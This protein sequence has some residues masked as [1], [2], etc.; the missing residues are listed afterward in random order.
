MSDP[1]DRTEPRSARPYDVRMAETEAGDQVTS[2]DTSWDGSALPRDILRTLD[3]PRTVE[4]VATQLEVNNA[5]VLWYLRKLEASG[6]VVVTGGRWTRTPEGS[7]L[8]A[9]P[10]S[11]PEGT[12]MP[13]QTVYDFRQA[14]ADAAAGM[15]GD[16]YVQAGGEHG[17][18]L[19]LEQA[20]EFR[21]R[22]TS[23]VAEYFAPG[24]GDRRGVKYGLH[25]TLT[26]TDLHPL[27]DDDPPA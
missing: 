13:G 14:F 24:K 4:Q 21:E 23:L 17:G 22:L 3:S 20:A 16:T 7:R 6:R 5:R 8:L 11:V 26:P 19:S 12:T 1:G 10:S 25:W 18:R 9:G 27:G 2:D 15:F